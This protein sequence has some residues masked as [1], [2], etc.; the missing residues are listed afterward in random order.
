[1]NKKG[2]IETLVAAHPGNRNAVK[3]GIYSP[4]TLAPRLQ[5][6]ETQFGERPAGEVVADLLLRELAAL[7]ALAEA[8]DQSLAADGCLGRRG[9]P[10]T[11]LLMTSRPST[12][13]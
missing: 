10:R 4:A 12:R 3:N 8:M 6:L 7:A 2:H 13:R 9:E 11:L 1:V 5:E